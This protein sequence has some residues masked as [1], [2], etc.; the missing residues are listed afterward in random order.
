LPGTGLEPARLSA[1]DPKSGASANS[2]TL[3]LQTH[4][5][6]HKTYYNLLTELEI[7]IK[8]SF[9]SPELTLVHVQFDAEER[10]GPPIIAKVA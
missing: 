8:A 4:S 7:P 2:A 5:K 6:M 10:F 9:D 1:P 3:A